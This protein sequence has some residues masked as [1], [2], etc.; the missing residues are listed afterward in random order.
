MN[1]EEI[2]RQ[3]DSKKTLIKKLEKEIQELEKNL[4]GEKDN[5][6][7]KNLSLD[8]KVSI[9]MDYFKGRDD[10]YPYLSINKDN[11]YYQPACKNEWVM[12]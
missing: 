12:K 4:Y 11:K 2:K 10:V 8:E 3:I 7:L 6:N 1:V 9:F 5:E